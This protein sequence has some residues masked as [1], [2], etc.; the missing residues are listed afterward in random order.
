[1]K[2]GVGT[3][4]LIDGENALFGA[5]DNLPNVRVVCVGFGDGGL[6]RVNHAAAERFFSDNPGILSRVRGDRHA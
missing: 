4:F 2:S 3:P 1:M 6:S 5:R